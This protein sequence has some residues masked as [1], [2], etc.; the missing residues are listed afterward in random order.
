MVSIA[1]S[2]VVA[3][4]P[5]LTVYVCFKAVAR[6]LPEDRETE[7]EVK[8][9]PPTIRRKIGPGSRTPEN[10]EEHGVDTDDDVAPPKPTRAIA[11][12]LRSTRAR[13]RR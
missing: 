5:Q 2:V 4:I 3:A 6:G 1:T 7:V 11:R 8:L 9:F 10:A 13:C 12:W